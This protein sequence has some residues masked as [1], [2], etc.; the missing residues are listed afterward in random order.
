MSIWA[1]FKQN[2]YEVYSH[3]AVATIPD[4]EL[5]RICKEED[6][7]A[8]SLGIKRNTHD[9]LMIELCIGHEIRRRRNVS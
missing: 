8:A 9:S 5:R 4:Q 2:G 1:R 6:A 3:D 7:Y